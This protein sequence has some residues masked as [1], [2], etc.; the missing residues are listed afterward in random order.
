MAGVGV[1]HYPEIVLRRYYL[2]RFY[3]SVSEART[4][5]NN[6]ILF[7]LTKLILNVRLPEGSPW[8][9]TC[10]GPASDFFSLICLYKLSN[11]SFTRY[12]LF[13][14]V[15]ECLRA[16]RLAHSC[17]TP[18][19]WDPISNLR[20]LGVKLSLPP[21]KY[22]NTNNYRGSVHDVCSVLPKSE[23]LRLGYTHFIYLKEIFWSSSKK[24]LVR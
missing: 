19:D 22:F 20:Y 17:T 13:M 7:L 4:S 23:P 11:Y 18:T 16:R 2:P 6:G 1:G 10:V 24:F 15:V 12:W 3:T 21:Q 9:I 5:I 14:G 8:C